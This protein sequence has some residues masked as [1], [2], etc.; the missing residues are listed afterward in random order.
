MAAGKTIA[1]GQERV[2]VPPFAGSERPTRGIEFMVPARSNKY[3]ASGVTSKLGRARK[4]AAIHQSVERA[5]LL[6][7]YLTP[8][9]R[10]INQNTKRPA[11]QEI[12]TCLNV[13][14]YLL[15]LYV[16]LY[17]FL[18]CGGIRSPTSGPTCTTMFTHLGGYITCAFLP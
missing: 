11:V 15:I 9:G 12:E 3:R 2:G 17:M 4:I 16:T 1:A 13:C 5:P 8:H 18:V 10:P 6:K 7:Y 14:Q